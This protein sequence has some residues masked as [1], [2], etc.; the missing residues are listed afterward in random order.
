MEDIDGPL[1]PALLER[2]A[3][4]PGHASQDGVGQ[5]HGGARDAV[6]LTALTPVYEHRKISLDSTPEIALGSSTQLI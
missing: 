1:A 6:L 3:A 4:R 5:N 2:G